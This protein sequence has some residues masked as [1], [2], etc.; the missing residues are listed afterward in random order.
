MKGGTESRAFLAWFLENYYRLDD[1]E[2]YDSICDGHGDKGIDG[3]YVNEQLKQIDFFQTTIA[4]DDSKKQGDNKIKSF[5]A[6]VVQF[7]TEKNAET[8]LAVANPELQALAK[9][10]NLVKR[11][12]EGFDIRGIFITN[13][14]ADSSAK[15]FLSTHR[16]IVLYDGVKLKSEFVTIAKTEPIASK[17]TFD[18][19]G[20]PTL[21]FPMGTNL[22][23]ILAPISAKEL[24]AMDG[25]SNG[26]LFAWNV[27]QFLGKGTS[28]NRAVAD[29][30]KKADQHIYFPAFHN[31][32][33]ILCKSLKSSKQ[34][35]EISGYAVVNG[36]QSITTLYE[37]SAAITNDLKI[38]T[39]FIK[40]TPDSP[41]AVK[42]TDHTNN[43]NGTKARDLQSNNSIH[44]R[45]Q[46]QIHSKYPEYHYRI[47]RGE[48]PEWKKNTV[49]EN[50]LLGR[51]LLA[52]D[53][54]RPEAWSQNYKLFDDLHAEIFGRP[55][56]TE[57]R[58]IYAHDTYGIVIEKMALMKDQLFATYTLSRWLVMYLVREALLTDSEGKKLHADPSSFFSKPNGR[59]RVRKCISSAAQ[60]IVRILDREIKL[61]KESVKDGEF[62]D[63]KKELK[64]REFI[65]A[66]EAKLIAQYQI[67]VDHDPKIGFSRQWSASAKK[68]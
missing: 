27:R 10:L 59:K 58:A 6:S 5:A 7:S 22:T 39:K 38:M 11:I 13:A 29:S 47:K 50:E 64:S 15:T 40:V 25:V 14:D 30:V 44:L 31:G 32:V 43:Q 42:I 66:L 12:K 17:F 67:V 45:L 46:T 56:V 34:T 48:H 16:N 21:E 19:S 1:C 52:F 35:I 62:F 26:D 2:L 55:Q 51:I 49:I 68:S 65:K 18:I 37:N 8:V 63:Y 36:C 54:D 60:T 23:M 24:I 4:K 28:V 9:R 57:D 41:L 61:L 53:L 33:T 3:I 20:Q